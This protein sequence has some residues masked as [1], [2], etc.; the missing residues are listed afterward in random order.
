M[1]NFFLLSLPILL[2]VGCGSPNLDDPNTLDYIIAEAIDEDKMQ[3]RGKEGEELFYSPNAQTPY[4]GWVKKLY[5]NGQVK[6]LYI[7]ENGKAN[8]VLL[9]GMRT[10]KGDGKKLQR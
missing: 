4:A 6:G 10:G 2:F 3:R 5:E 8:G 7:L 9:S 1:R